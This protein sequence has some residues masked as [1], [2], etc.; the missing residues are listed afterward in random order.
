MVEF[1]GGNGIYDNYNEFKEGELVLSYALE[2]CH[3]SK[4]DLGDNQYTITKKSNRPTYSN[5]I[6]KTKLYWASSELRKIVL[7]TK[8]ARCYYK[9]RIIG[10]KD[11]Y[12]IIENKYSAE[13]SGLKTGENNE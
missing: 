8:V 1:M 3:L 10:T 2:G 6:E 12:I 5:R 4:K 9:G 7:D 13:T 11:K